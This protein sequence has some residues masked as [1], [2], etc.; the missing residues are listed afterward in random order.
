MSECFFFRRNENTPFLQIRWKEWAF[1]TKRGDIFT[2]NWGAIF[3]WKKS[4]WH[5]HEVNWEGN[6][7][8]KSWF[9]FCEKWSKQDRSLK[10]LWRGG[11]HTDYISQRM[12]MNKCML[13][14]YVPFE[15]ESMFTLHSIQFM[16]IKFSPKLFP[17]PKQSCV[18]VCVCVSLQLGY[19]QVWFC[20]M[21]H[22]MLEFLWRGLHWWSINVASQKMESWCFRWFRVVIFVDVSPHSAMFY[23]LCWSC[24]DIHHKLPK[25]ESEQECRQWVS[26]TYLLQFILAKSAIQ[27]VLFRF[28][29]V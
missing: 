11:H 9:F 7:A 3:L 14:C 24:N 6:N 5:F 26:Y 4:N 15:R 21:F 20:Y 12:H 17:T 16:W 1:C 27:F 29:Y 13:S 18:C 25:F 8:L 2:F 19:F 22:V 23:M 28:V 10:N